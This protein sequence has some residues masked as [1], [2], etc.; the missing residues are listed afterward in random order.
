MNISLGSEVLWKLQIYMF[1]FISGEY[2]GRFWGLAQG[3][4]QGA[5]L[6]MQDPHTETSSHIHSGYRPFCAGCVAAVQTNRSCWLSQTILMQ[7]GLIRAYYFSLL[8]WGP[9]FGLF[10]SALVLS[11]VY[12]GPDYK[13]T[14]VSFLL[15]LGHKVL[16]PVLIANVYIF[17]S[18]TKKYVLMHW[19]FQ[20][21]EITF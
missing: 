14:V 11:I 21:K 12:Q 19:V 16:F 18:N 13:I 8:L 20:L 1:V 15:N 4:G 7:T 2:P 3:N 5:W 6:C 17:L 10:C 9:S